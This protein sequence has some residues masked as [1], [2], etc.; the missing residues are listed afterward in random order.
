MF[1]R[2][3]GV[4]LAGLLF[5]AQSRSTE[6]APIVFND[7]A[8]FDA[9]AQPNVFDDFSA[10][11]QCTVVNTFCHLTYSGVTFVYDV[12]DFPIVPFGPPQS[13]GFM[14]VGP[15]FVVGMDFSPLTALGFDVSPVGDF[16]LKLFP[17]ILQPDGVEIF[18]AAFTM[19][20]PGFFGL[21]F[22]D[23]SVLTGLGLL[24]NQPAE[25]VVAIDNLAATAPVAG[26]VTVPEPAT[27]LLF[28]AGAAVVL[29]RRRNRLD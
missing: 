23:G 29:G 19:T 16:G 17:R 12:A 13:I 14:N 6:A 26:A 8:A 27:L 25:T 24:P 2:C 10:P 5:L 3:V 20:Q 21:A 1:T 7:R 4:T 28:G 11:V 15:T 18:G 22:D 9:A